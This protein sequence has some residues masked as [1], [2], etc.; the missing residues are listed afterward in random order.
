MEK[1][2]TNSTEAQAVAH[3]NL[4]VLYERGGMPQDYSK[5]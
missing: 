5:A 4:G 2:E 3:Y 1:S